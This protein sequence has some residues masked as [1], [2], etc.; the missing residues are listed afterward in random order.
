[1]TSPA[2]RQHAIPMCKCREDDVAD[3]SV[4]FLSCS[5]GYTNQDIKNAFFWDVSP[6]GSCMK[7][8]LTTLTRRNIPEDGVN[9]LSVVA[10]HVLTSSHEA[11]HGH[12]LYCS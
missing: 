8:V 1:M 11:G 10:R 9:I 6:C 7:K 4:R 2:L 3:E 5:C 12:W